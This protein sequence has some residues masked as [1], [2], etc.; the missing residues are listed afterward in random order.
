MQRSNPSD[1]MTNRKFKRYI[2]DNPKIVEIMQMLGFSLGFGDLSVDEVCKQ[3]GV[4]PELFAALCDI[5]TDEHSQPD[6]DN[7]GVSDIP[8]L[9]SFLHLTHS[10]YLETSLDR[11]HE[12]VHRMTEHCSPENSLIVNRFFD[13][14]DA[15][16]K[17]HIE[18]EENVVFKYINGLL[19]GEKDSML[20]I[21]MLNEMHS[22]VDEKLEDFKNIVMNYL[23]PS[24][25]SD[26]RY[27]VLIEIMG[28]SQALRHHMAAE[29]KLL[30][31]LAEMLEEEDVNT[32]EVKA[33]ERSGGSLS[34]IPDTLLSEREREIIA[35]VAR[36][37]TN[38]EIAD[39][40]FISVFTVTTHRKNISRKLGIKTIAGLTAYALMNG[41][42]K[43]SDIKL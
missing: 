32:L 38:K 28:I 9:L 36:G 27:D 37:L 13:D 4:N 2:G 11:L 23:P 19:N 3:N 39:K 30:L 26:D 31:P 15:E 42:I 12:A 18:F 41:Y 21:G 16:M 20:S 5:Y 8:V 43:E 22:N 14:Y 33:P 6:I 1:I 17:K 7:L 24:S 34:D 10:S 35:E 25:T 29:D 40:L